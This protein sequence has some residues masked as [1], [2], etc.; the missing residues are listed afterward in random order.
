MSNRRLY[1]FWNVSLI[2]SLLWGG[3]MAVRALYDVMQQQQAA[4][5]TLT[6]RC[7]TL[8]DAY[9]TMLASH[10]KSLAVSEQLLALHERTIQLQAN[11]VLLVEEQ[12]SLFASEGREIP[13]KALTAPA[14]KQ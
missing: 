8:H 11:V 4:Y 3:G 6:G 12:F 7:A 2:I 5:Q 10:T 14:S 9:V 1:I 13:R